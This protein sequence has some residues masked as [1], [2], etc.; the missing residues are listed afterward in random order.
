MIPGA[1][2]DVAFKTVTDAILVDIRIALDQRNRRHHHAW[3]TETALQA[4]VLAKRFLH[5]MHLVAI[6]EALDGADFGAVAFPRE[7]GATLD[8]F[9]VQFDDAGTA[10]AGVASYVRAC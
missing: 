6:G 8:G 9:V 5:R 10:L 4:V 1:A 3:C 2:A 7:N